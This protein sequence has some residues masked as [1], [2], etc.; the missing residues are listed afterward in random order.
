MNVTGQLHTRYWS[1]SPLFSYI[2][3]VAKLFYYG[4]KKK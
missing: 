2:A 3:G 4:I 1:H